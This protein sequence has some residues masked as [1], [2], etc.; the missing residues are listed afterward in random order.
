MS[1]TRAAQ[2]KMGSDPK[3]EG[4]SREGRRLALLI[5]GTGVAYIGVQIIGTSLGW[6][7]RTMGFFDLATLAI[8]G[9]AL[10]SAFMIWRSRQE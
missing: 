7:A 3:H 5:A 2:N 4:T 6:T 10:V 9:Y 1:R 8:F